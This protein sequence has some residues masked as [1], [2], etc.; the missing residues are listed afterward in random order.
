MDE[1]T[2]SDK[3]DGGS[4]IL[5]AYASQ[6]GSTAE[7]AE[8]IA[9]VLGQEGNMVSTSHVGSVTDLNCYDAVIIGSAIQYDRWMP[10]ARKFVTT[11][12]HILSAL[13]VAFFFTCLT[14]SIKSEKA[15]RQAMTYSDKIRALAPQVEPVDVGCFAGVLDYS[16]LSF[17][18]RLISKAFFSIMG[19][20]EGDY[21]DWDA[22]RS[23]AK[24]ANYKLA[25]ERSSSLASI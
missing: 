24:S 10:E 2:I 19:V 21:R 1:Q 22:I 16:R 3:N 5:V 23:W 4:S 8:A 9:E 15:E 17:F 6:F 18:W 13:P 20:Q 12:Q 11:H 7:V 25:K 14:L